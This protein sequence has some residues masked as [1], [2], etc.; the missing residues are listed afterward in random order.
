MNPSAESVLK[1]SGRGGFRESWKLGI[2]PARWAK[3]PFGCDP[4]TMRAKVESFDS[5]A[6]RVIRPLGVTFAQ[7]YV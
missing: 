7:A 3:L 2:F 6:L 1:V 5:K 4:E